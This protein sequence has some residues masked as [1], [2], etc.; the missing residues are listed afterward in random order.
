MNK[1]ST[2]RFF[3]FSF[4]N[5][6]FFYSIIFNEV[7]RIALYIYWREHTKDAL[8]VYFYFYVAVAMA[9]AVDLVISWIR[10]FY[11]SH[12]LKIICFSCVHWHTASVN[13]GW[14]GEN[15]FVRFFFRYCSVLFCCE[16]ECR[17]FRLLQMA[18]WLHWLHVQ[19]VKLLVSI[20][21]R[22]FNALH[23]SGDHIRFVHLIHFFQILDQLNDGDHT[24]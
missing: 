11:F 7:Q 21:K 5:F 10:F 17:W 18:Q 4:S 8:L 20:H 14:I 1:T 3:F 23:E 9:V 2:S 24:A 13:N 22:Y 16:E 12:L 15:H 19:Y 6:F